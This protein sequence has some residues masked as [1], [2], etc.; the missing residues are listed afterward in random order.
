MNVERDFQKYFDKQF[1]I[2]KYGIMSRKTKQILFKIIQISY[3]YQEPELK[4]VKLV[5]VAEEEAC[6]V[7]LKHSRHN[8]K[9]NFLKQ[10]PP[11]TPP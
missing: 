6:Q 2:F 11:E 4:K 8:H 3:L 1:Q 7:L 9:M 10:F 5:L